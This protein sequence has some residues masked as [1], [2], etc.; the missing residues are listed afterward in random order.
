MR[1]SNVLLL[2]VFGLTAL[3]A[4]TGFA[5]SQ[6]VDLFEGNSFQKW[7][8]LNNKD[9]DE[10]ILKNWKF[11]DDG[12][13][14]LYN[15]GGG[16][17]SLMLK[18]EVGDFELSFF[19]KIHKN[20]NNGIKTRV[21]KYGNKQLGI[22]YQLLDDDVQNGKTIPKHRTGSIY[23]LKAPSESK[24]LN[25]PGELNHSRIRIQDQTLEHWLNGTLVASTKIGSQEWSE[26]VKKS[27]FAPNKA[28]GENEM[29]QIMITD[30]GGQIWFRDVL[31]RKLD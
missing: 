9:G 24:P 26:L 25:V 31:L 14:H 10:A 28:F 16:G 29:G 13:L 15:P 11:T 23:D 30:H 6:W 1:A 19:W 4:N 7:T 12:W 27:K 2:L 22:E 3:G 5:Q 17:S 8:R 21:R 18:E 20:A